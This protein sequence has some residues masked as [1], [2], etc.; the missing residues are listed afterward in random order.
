MVAAGCADNNTSTPP[1]VVVRD[2]S[3]I[4][5]SD[6]AS[7]QTMCGNCHIGM[8]ARWANTKHASAW[9]DL[10][11]SGHAS[12]SCNKCHTTNGATNGAAD[13]TAGYFKVGTDSKPLYQDVQCE[14][15]H[16]AG[17][18][19]ALSPDSTQ[20]LPDI[21]VD[22]GLNTGCGTCHSGGHDP[23]VEEWRSSTHGA[24]NS[25]ATSASCLGCHNGN[26]AL[27]RIQPSV[28]FTNRNSSTAPAVGVTC[29]VCHDPHGSPNPAQLTRPLN[30]LDTLTNLCMSCHYRRSQP[31]S[32][33]TAGSR[34]SPHAP[35]A[36]LVTG[37][38]GWQPAGFTWSADQQPTHDNPTANPR[39]CAACHVNGFSGKNDAG[40]TVY[41]MGHTFNPTPCVTAGGAPDTTTSCTEDQKSFKACTASGCHTTETA[42]R[43]ALAAVD[44]RMTFYADAIWIDKNAN[45]LVDTTDGGLLAQVKKV[46]PT[47][48]KNNDAITPA[49]GAQFN[50]AL[51]R[52]AGTGAHN[53]FYTEALAV[54]TIN[55]LK[56]TY[57]IAAPAA[58]QSYIMNRLAS[59]PYL[60]SVAR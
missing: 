2:A 47:A 20:P 24:P 27:A 4:G 44:G 8:Q 57:G 16:G 13:T 60:R 39:L 18:V 14:S 21:A 7:K 23:F 51:F 38:A 30:T 33:S 26:V 40:T 19:H 52:M 9:A 29:E 43:G 56:T 1:V 55:A 45:G 35:Q 54:A 36:L 41:S 6:T 10:Q 25:H 46:A 59:A 28:N 58:V 17:S 15:C 34:N 37:A 50:V 53:P 3:F 48:W 22:T 11:A 5:Y 12:A 49:E 42:A 31:D 32:T